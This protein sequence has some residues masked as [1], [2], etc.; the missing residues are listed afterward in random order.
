M[1]AVHMQLTILAAF[2]EISRTVLSMCGAGILVFLVA[3]WAA[4]DDIAQAR[5]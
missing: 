2:F 3:L 1:L 5:G 4:R